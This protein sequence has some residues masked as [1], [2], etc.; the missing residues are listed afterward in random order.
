MDLS[1]NAE[2][3][4]DLLALLRFGDAVSEMH[5]RLVEIV[6]QLHGD[7][8]LANASR[9]VLRYLIAGGPQTVPQIA[10]WRATSR[11]FIQR[12]VTELETRGLVALADNPK[13]RRSPRVTVTAKGRAQVRA[14]IVKEARLLN[15][16]LVR[17]GASVT[18][19]K[20]ATELVERFRAVV[21]DLIREQT[22]ENER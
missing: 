17:S 4:E 3:P 13:H 21:E 7:R 19:V 9:G 14:M 5:F 10:A 22:K 1:Q 11:Q 6:G 8:H 18:E 20:S 2:L 16:G 12:I 15:E